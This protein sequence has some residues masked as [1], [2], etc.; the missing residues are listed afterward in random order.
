[1]SQR[2]NIFLLLALA[3]GLGYGRFVVPLLLVSEPHP[4]EDTSEDAGP[5]QHGE[6]WFRANP[7]QCRKWG[8]SARD[9]HEVCS[10][11]IGRPILRGQRVDDE[12]L[13]V[14]CTS[15]LPV[16]DRHVFI[17]YLTYK[18]V[19]NVY[20]SYGAAER[21]PR[22]SPDGTIELQKFADVVRA[23]RV[24][25]RHLVAPLDDHDAEEMKRALFGVL[26]Q[27]RRDQQTGTTTYLA[28]DQ[29]TTALLLKKLRVLNVAEADIQ[30]IYGEV[31]FPIGLS[32]V[33]SRGGTK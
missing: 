31:E 12:I 23:G 19:L 7:V 27:L 10:T 33:F 14:L 11:G 30:A 32:T 3:A 17:T 20:T 9:V 8:V 22:C 2:A 24:R 25:I 16:L 6:L 29:D 26:L 18:P 1:M 4:V 13:I 15:E 28:G 21:A 5:E